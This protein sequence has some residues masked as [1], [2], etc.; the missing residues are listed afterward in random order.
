MPTR[1][2]AYS[3]NELPNLPFSNGLA[4]THHS[5]KINL[6][7]K[8]NAMSLMASSKRM[9]NARKAYGAL[10]KV[11]SHSL[12]VVGVGLCLG[13]GAG[14]A[15]ATPLQQAVGP[16]TFDFLYPTTLN[17]T[18]LGMF[19]FPDT[20]QTV[21][22]PFGIGVEAATVDGQRIDF[23]PTPPFEIDVAP[24]TITVRYTEPIT[25]GFINNDVAIIKMTTTQSRLI[26]L[27]SL[28]SETGIVLTPGAFLFGSN[29]FQVALSS[30]SFISPGATLD[31]S[32]SYNLSTTPV[33]EPAT[34][35][36]MLIGFA[37]LGYAGYRRAREQRAAV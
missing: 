27:I 11:G 13:I 24:A 34:W 8:E 20:G 21:S 30:A 7:K 22:V 15:A 2:N 4:P 10:G 1:P 29:F 31:F 17:D 35:A 28:K 32:V 37:G 5:N 26:N 33:P 14:T 3:G 18:N 25:I 12:L 16:L 23:T 19:A 6:L 9:S 36:M